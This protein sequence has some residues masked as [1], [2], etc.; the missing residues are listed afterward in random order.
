MARYQRVKSMW[1]FLGN[2]CLQE[3]ISKLQ[4]TSIV[5]ETPITDLLVPTLKCSSPQ[6]LKD[7]LNIVGEPSTSSWEPNSSQEI[8]FRLFHTAYM[9]SVT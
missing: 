6:V 2:F 5:F 7:L 9:V 3:A 1:I 4:E 8:A